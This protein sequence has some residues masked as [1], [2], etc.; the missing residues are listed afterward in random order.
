MRQVR[1]CPTWQLSDENNLLLFCFVEVKFIIMVVMC[2]KR[3]KM[4]RACINKIKK[5]K[6]VIE[7]GTTSL[8]VKRSKKGEKH[9]FALL[10][11]H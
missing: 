9:V 6:K 3:L 5:E 10:T 2:P 1:K 8:K 11:R 4:M 7:Q